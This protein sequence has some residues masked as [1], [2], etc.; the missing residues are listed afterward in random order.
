MNAKSAFCLLFCCLNLVAAQLVAQQLRVLTPSK[1][2]DITETAL[3]WQNLAF[4]AEAFR[5][6]VAVALSATDS[7]LV[8]WEKL[9]EKP[10]IANLSRYRGYLLAQLNRP[11][12]AKAEMQRALAL[13]QQQKA[14]YGLAITHFDLGRV[15]LFAHEIDSALYYTG[16]SLKSWQAQKQDSR[17]FLAKIQLIYLF[18]LQFNFP[19][20][21]RLQGELAE[22]SQQLSLYR[23]WQLDYWF[24]N[25]FLSEKQQ[26][27]SAY[28][29]YQQQYQ[30]LIAEFAAEGST[31]VSFYNR[32]QDFPARY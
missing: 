11:K 32:P 27:W 28:E 16:I 12:E 29:S 24:V 19:E 26:N 22:A 2:K 30:S 20:A 1:Y 23:L 10:E 13:Y 9:G 15:C 14:V 31:V 7:A 8:L 18:T 5:G 6:D 3:D 21:E 25:M 17:I 4:V